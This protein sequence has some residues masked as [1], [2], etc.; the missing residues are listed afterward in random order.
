VGKLIHPAD[1]IDEKSPAREQPRRLRS[2]SGKRVT[3]EPRRLS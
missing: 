1:K 3:Q 2:S